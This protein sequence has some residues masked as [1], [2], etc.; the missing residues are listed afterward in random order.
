MCGIYPAQIK[1][2]R[3]EFV[4]CF[5]PFYKASLILLLIIEAIIQQFTGD[6]SGWE[7]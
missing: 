6:F 4:N 7:I 1:T 3:E 5:C 2:K